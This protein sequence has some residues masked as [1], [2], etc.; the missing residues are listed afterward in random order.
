MT[1]KQWKFP[2]LLYMRK[3]WR[4]GSTGSIEK[5]GVRLGSKTVHDKLLFLIRMRSWLVSLLS[6]VIEAVGRYWREKSLRLRSKQLPPANWLEGTN[7][8]EY[9]PIHW[10]FNLFLK[11]RHLLWLHGWGSLRWDWLWKTKLSCYWMVVYL[12]I[13][14]NNIIVLWLFYECIIGGIL[15]WCMLEALAAHANLW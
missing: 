13:K 7:R 4:W 10:T 3:D 6:W 12:Q 15:S 11:T 9:K 5:L 8:S 14:T 2:D 1:T